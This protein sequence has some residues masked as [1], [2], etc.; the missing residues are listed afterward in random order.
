MNVITYSINFIKRF[1][2][3][4]ILNYAYLEEYGQVESI[5]SIIEGVIKR[6]CLVDSNIVAGITAY[7]RLSESMVIEKDEFNNKIITIP[8][9]VL[10][11]NKIL[12]VHSIVQDNTI[13]ETGFDYKGFDADIN[14]LLGSTNRIMTNIDS[15]FYVDV[16]A[17]I[18]IIGERTIHIMENISNLDGTVAKLVIENQNLMSNLNTRAYMVFAKLALLAIKADIYNRTIIKMDSGKLT[19]GH[20]LGVIKSKIE[21]FSDANEQYLEY[22]ESKW[23]K[24]TYFANDLQMNSLVT[25][26][27]PNNL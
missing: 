14:S 19:Y 20:D 25:T 3:K 10:G 9:D 24:T 13:S 11:D 27:F 26:M 7:L 17:N 5:E 23:R 6:T 15:S 12:S 1:I 16:T 18:S 2:P 21:E 8:K 22:F 4:E